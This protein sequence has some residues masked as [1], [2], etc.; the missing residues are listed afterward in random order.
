[1]AER[2]SGWP[3]GSGSCLSAL[4]YNA[5]ESDSNRNR[6]EQSPWIPAFAGMTI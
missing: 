3:Y 4:L 2:F 1:M 6:K 5:I